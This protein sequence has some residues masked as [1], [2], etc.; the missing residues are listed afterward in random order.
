MPLQGELVLRNN[1]AGAVFSPPV[2]RGGFKGAISID[3]LQSEGNATLDVTVQTKNSADPDDS[4]ATGWG[5]AHTDVA[6]SVN[7][8][9][10]WAAGVTGIK[11]VVPVQLK[12]MVRLKF[13]VGTTSGAW[14][15]A[16]V[17]TP[18]WQ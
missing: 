9:I 10:S 13:T 11:S 2:L 12:E 8:T 17:L 3:V 7:A 16:A 14:I 15:R 5:N 4:G 18:S 6:G 1:L